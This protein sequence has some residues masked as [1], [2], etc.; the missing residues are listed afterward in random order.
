ML[1]SGKVRV[2]LM[3]RRVMYSS[4]GSNLYESSGAKR[5]RALASEHGTNKELEEYEYEERSDES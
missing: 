5:E 4:Q 2:S 3:K 1:H